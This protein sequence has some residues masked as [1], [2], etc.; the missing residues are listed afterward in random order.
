MDD[1]KAVV[2]VEGDKKYNGQNSLV[3]INVLIRML[4]SKVIE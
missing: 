3:I 2:W 4:T 1:K